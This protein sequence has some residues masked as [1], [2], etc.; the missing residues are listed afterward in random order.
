VEVVPL[1]LVLAI[2]VE[3]LDP[4]VLTVGHIDPAILGSLGHAYARAGRTADALRVLN[5]LQNR[6]AGGTYVPPF[7]MALI[8]A[9]LCLRG[10]CGRQVI[11]VK[12]SARWSEAESCLSIIAASA[13][14]IQA[15]EIICHAY[16]LQSSSTTVARG[17]LEPA[18]QVFAILIEGIWFAQ[19]SPLE[20][21]G[22]ELSVPGDG[23]SRCSRF[24]AARCSGWIGAP[25]REYRGSARLSC[26]V[27]PPRCCRIRVGELHVHPRQIA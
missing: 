13:S 24:C 7:A 19:E 14:R 3:Y 4:V 25:G 10:G 9:G 12:V 26:A 8:R 5:D 18:R 16:T 20:G 11:D 23:Q 6:Q 22:F 1:G 17:E 27:S 2:A 21:G 15:P